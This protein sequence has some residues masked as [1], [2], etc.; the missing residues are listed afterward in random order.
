M[1]DENILLFNKNY[2]NQPI[3]AINGILKTKST[4]PEKENNSGSSIL[5][6]III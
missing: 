3:N 5:L 4:S 2:A 1:S 6:L